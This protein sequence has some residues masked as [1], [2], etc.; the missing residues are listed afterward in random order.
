MVK[1]QLFWSLL[2]A[3][4]SIACWT[5]IAD[6]ATIEFFSP[7]GTAKK[8]D[9]VKVRFSDQM[10][11]FGD[12][13]LTGPF[14]IS[15]SEK[16]TGR[17]IDGKN[18]SYDF[19]RDLPSGVSCVFRL[20]KGLKSLA[21]KSIVG[22]TSFR[23]NTGGPSVITAQPYEG[24]EYIDEQQRF[25]FFLDGD[26]DDTSLTQNVYCSIEG[27]KERVGIRLL[28][29]SEKNDFLKS[30]GHDKDQ[31]PV[32]VFDCRQQ[33]PSQARID[34]I[35]GKGVKSK[36][37]IA[38]TKDQK[39]SYKTR[40]PFSV[41]F[42]CMKEDPKAN[43]MPLS[44]M[45]LEFS[46]PVPWNFVR[47]ITLKNEKGQQWKPS[48]IEYSHAIAYLVS[49]AKK[50]ETDEKRKD[51][52]VQSISFEGPFPEN[53]PFTIDI[54][55][56]LKDDTGRRLTNEKKFPLKVMTHSYPP[57]AKFSGHFGIIEHTDE[58][59][60]PVTV[61]NIEETIQAWAYQT[62]LPEKGATDQSKTGHGKYLNLTQ[63]VK[64]KVRD[65][66]ADNEEVII[67][68]LKRLRFTDRRESVLKGTG[69]ETTFTVPKPGPSKEFEVIGIPLKDK[70]FYV[71]ELESKLL[72]ERLLGKPQPIHIPTSVLVSNMV[73]HFKWGRESSLVWVTS[74]DK[75]QPVDAAHVTLRDCSGNVIWRG[76]TDRDG[77]A[78]IG[79]ALPSK[80][81]LTKCPVER[82]DNQ[83]NWTNFE[84][85]QLLSGITSGI[86][87]FASKGNDLTF[88]H[89][90]WTGGI[91]PWRFNLPTRY[92]NGDK[93]NTITHTVFDRQLFRSGETVSMKHFIREQDMTHGI[94]FPTGKELPDMLIIQHVGTDQEYSFP[95]QWTARGTAETTWKIPENAKL[96]TYRT[97]LL[98][99]GDKSVRRKVV[100]NTG[101]FEVQEFR[102]PLMRASVKGPKEPVINAKDVDVDIS[103]TYLSGGGASF[104]PVKLR[105]E[106]RP[107]FIN[108]EDYSEYMF[109][110]GYAKKSLT[111]P[112]PAHEENGPQE[113]S[114]VSPGRNG[115]SD[116]QEIKLKTHD[117]TLDATGSARL[118]LSD[119]PEI[120]TP[121]DILSEL[122]FKDPNGETQTVSSRIGLYPSRIHAGITI[123]KSGRI[124]D[125]LVYKVIAVDLKGKP[126]PGAETV[127]SL[128]KKNIYTHRRRVAGGFYSYKSTTELVEAG[129]HCQG[130]TDAQGILTC[131][132]KPPVEGEIIL[133]AEVRDS[134]GNISTAYTETSIYGREDRWFEMGDDDRIDLVP[135]KKQYEPGEKARFQVK[136]PF[137]EATALITIEREGVIDTSIQRLTRNNPVIE[138][139]VKNSY[140]PNIFI[141]AFIVRGRVADAKPSAMFDPGKPAYKMGI[142]ELRVGW[143][144]HELKVNITT[145]KKTYPVR[146]VVDVKI[147]VTTAFG[148]S[149]PEAGEVTIAAVDEGLLELKGNE[150]WKLLEAMMA[151]R[152]YE[153]NTSTAQMMVVGKRHFGRKSLSYGGGGG[154]QTTREL[155]D[156]LLLWKSSV[157]LNDNGEATV[158]IPLNDSLTSFRIVAIAS[159]GASFFGTGSATVNTTQDLMVIS[160]IPPLA[161]EGDRFFA[162]FTI[163]NTSDRLMD[164]RALLSTTDLKERKDLKPLDMKL[165]AGESR[166]IGW[167][168][169]VPAG[170]EKLLYEA[171]AMDKIENVTDTV[172]ITQKVAPTVP[173]RTFQ[174]TLA[175][176]KE[177]HRIAVQFPPD[178][179]PSR[180]GIRVSIKPKLAEGLG[181]VTEYMKDYPYTCF[182]QKVSRAIALRDKKIWGSLMNDLPSYLDQDGLIKYFPVR[183]ISGT[184]TLT[185][186]ILSI[187]HEAGY[188]IPKIPKEKML[189]GLKGFVQGRVVRWSNLPTADLSIRKL[190]ALEALSRYDEAQANLLESVTIEPDLWPT[191]A[192]IDWI[193][194]LSRVTD[195][196]DRL[197][198][199]KKAQ[200][201]LR[202]RLILQGTAMNFSTERSDYCWW[203]MVSSDTNA[204]KTLLTALQFDSWN[205]DSPGIARGVVGRLRHGR[206]NTTVANAW[207]IIAMDKFSKK[208]ESLPVGGITWSTFVNKTVATDWVK[209]PNGNES[210]FSWPQ[211]NEEIFIK[212]E[213]TGKPWVTIQSIAAIPLKESLASGFKIKKTIT[214]IEQKAAG[215]WTRGDVVRVNL[216][217]D[218]QS[219][220]AWVVVNDPIPAGS[221]ILGGGLG[222]DSSI[223]TKQETGKGLVQEVFRERSFES[224]RAYFE[225]IARG[226]FTIEYTMRLNN[227]G[228][229]NLP[230]TRVEALYQ[231]EMFGEL[232]NAKMVVH[233]Q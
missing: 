147:K 10:V 162:R 181:S 14:D 57:L 189:E 146:Q 66:G 35:W 117:L 94:T 74:L 135:E 164:I 87:V 132:G 211:K 123:V 121:R 52:T 225:Y 221:T 185:A 110:N 208:F 15:C 86:F 223:L 51:L 182:E 195:I 103:L 180:G 129:F 20:K 174:A 41:T 4:F 172:K 7:E 58:T 90:S 128:L 161:R 207:G 171:R 138:V 134:A 198:K 91:D 166:E 98:Q 201:I 60:L 125:P 204:I 54:P 167:D 194:I 131:E 141:S 160:G 48:K 209:T 156:T 199:M 59:S 170:T 6:A 16:G 179:V 104:A 73:A 231:P 64:G 216:E 183:F 196:P 205:V 32:T 197:G 99:K 77:I 126:V 106:I 109:S 215:K 49:S 145:D 76:K 23:F 56:G 228:A 9:Q 148:K 224:M 37:G 187:A 78:K 11:A 232:P 44:P 165:P 233:P 107:R 122:E 152:P 130:K 46:S 29:G 120:D 92:D 97:F 105:S 82:K 102:I 72:G 186:Y 21:G 159:A 2:F 22:Q 193:G 55:R 176:L 71:V 83:D 95:L 153:I 192:V 5:V 133:Q 28:T 218:S 190:S 45:N 184:D 115:R 33:F 150:S 114:F 96:G 69:Q 67:E 100:W 85:S 219:D 53:T 111:K 26:P 63:E 89:S 144:K 18:W 139:P 65:L 30:I 214:P 119:L 79:R 213:G 31:A 116:G 43:C 212:H 25:V 50:P 27:I 12:P 222:R 191:S 108:F 217:I 227:E 75:A 142:T 118:N 1:R 80:D 70:G 24:D 188:Q 124:E 229:F 136:M 203:L 168:V 157:P 8:V 101:S 61:R 36:T 137:R 38:T 173:L 200:S 206:W 68:W 3:L 34:I 178:A 93:G 230:Q 151:R 84:D 149:P 143:Q 220:M 163:R 47:D 88:T 202:S 210:F 140:A 154:K 155:F 169:T 17:W 158:K 112:L 40:T 113:D 19:D 175:Q 81:K 42:R 226:K 127:V 13:Q 62:G 39:I 177:Q